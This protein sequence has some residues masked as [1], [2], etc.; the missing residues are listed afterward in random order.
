MTRSRYL[1]RSG[2]RR[3]EDGDRRR[4]AQGGRRLG[5][6]AEMG[7]LTADQVAAV[8]SAADAYVAAMNAGDWK[9]VAQSFA[10]DAVRI[11]PHEAPHQG[12]D[13]I[14]AWLGGIEELLSYELTRDAVDGADGFAVRPWALRDHA[15]PAGRS[16][17]DLRRRRLP[18]GLAP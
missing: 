14:E 9:L 5:R 10:E 1:R 13:A 17:S 6:M 12:R 2:S 8:E 16:R 3:A 11:P 15:P 4:H 7:K 18:R